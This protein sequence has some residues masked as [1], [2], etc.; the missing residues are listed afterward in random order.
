VSF[1]IFFLSLLQKR[2]AVKTD[3]LNSFIQFP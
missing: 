3:L 1:K 2:P